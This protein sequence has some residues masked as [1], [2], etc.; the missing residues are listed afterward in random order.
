MQAWHAYAREG[1]RLATSVGP[2]GGKRVVLEAQPLRGIEEKIR[3]DTPANRNMRC[4][5]PVGG[6]DIHWKSSGSGIVHRPESKRSQ[7]YRYQ[8]LLLDRVARELRG[9]QHI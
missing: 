6:K 8:R 1:K 2:K 4:S 5:A 3:R 7:Q 9:A